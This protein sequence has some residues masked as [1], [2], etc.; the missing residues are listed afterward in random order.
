MSWRARSP[1]LPRRRF[2]EADLRS[3]ALKTGP[4]VLVAEADER[5]RA[6]LRDT[7]TQ[8]GY[9]VETARTGAGAIARAYERKYD[10][11]TLN[12][13]LPDI[14]DR[15]VLSY[16]R[17]DGPNIETPLV[18][19]T[20]VADTAL[21]G[22]FDVHDIITKPFTNEQLVASVSRAGIPKHDHRPILVVDD[23]PSVL[24]LAE[25]TLSAAGYRC[26]CRSDGGS[27]LQAA[28][29][30]AP[31]AVVLDLDMPGMDGL[32]VLDELRRRSA[33]HRIPVLVWTAHEPPAEKRARL[34][35]K[36]QGLI[37]KSAGLN[38][39]IERL[40]FYVPPPREV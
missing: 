11:I 17:A 32:Q 22:G 30:E 28:K 40:R 14:S 6:W 25:A 33:S 2:H 1:S 21:M 24:K 4:T 18:V 10:V 35:A 26:V 34:L 3:N 7:L 20:A 9:A 36:A 27:A 37:F 39:L 12:L 23:D 8:A 29:D 19:V 16:I 13:P 15:D 5:D 38:A 31:A